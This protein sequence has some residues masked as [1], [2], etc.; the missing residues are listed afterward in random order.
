MPFYLL[1]FFYKH[2]KAI[3]TIIKK[4][5]LYYT[6]NVNHVL[7]PYIQIKFILTDVKDMEYNQ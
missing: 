1:F 6:H 3:L 7:Y 5:K 4:K 2:L